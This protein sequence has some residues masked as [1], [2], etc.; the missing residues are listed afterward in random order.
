M[1]LPYR[2][3]PARVDEGD[4]DYSFGPRSGK[5]EFQDGKLT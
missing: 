4:F 1:A 2:E 5:T 3:G